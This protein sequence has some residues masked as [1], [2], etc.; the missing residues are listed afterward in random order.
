MPTSDVS[1]YSYVDLGSGKGRTLF[2][3]AELQFGQ[4]TRVEFSPRLH[5]EACANILRFR[6]WKRRGGQIASVLCNAKDFVFPE[7]NTVLYLFK[8]FGADTMQHV[9]SHLETSLER[10]PRHV[11]DVLLWPRC[12]DMVALVKGMRLHCKTEHHQISK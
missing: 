1:G 2:V 11:I 6:R 7:A 5:Q 4:I 9:L 8:P 10:H 3:A 12:Q